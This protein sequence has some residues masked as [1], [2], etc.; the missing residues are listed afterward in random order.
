MYVSINTVLKQNEIHNPCSLC[1]DRHDVEP[2]IAFQVNLLILR[3][4]ITLPYI[5]IQGVILNFPWFS[6]IDGLP[7]DFQ[8][9]PNVPETFLKYGSNHA[10]SRWSNIQK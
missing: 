6:G 7:I 2:V 8:P 1:S 9:G 4:E 10:I 3:V 5:A